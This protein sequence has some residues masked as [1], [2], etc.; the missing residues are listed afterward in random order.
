M[1]GGTETTIPGLI[2]TGLVR[3]FG[4]YNVGFKGRV[5]ASRQELIGE[6]EGSGTRKCRGT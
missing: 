2:E 3:S 5:R 1:V 4:K 6:R